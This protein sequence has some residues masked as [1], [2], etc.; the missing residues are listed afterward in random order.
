MRLTF[1]EIE[2]EI[3]PTGSAAWNGGKIE[4]FSIAIDFLNP[5]RNARVIVEENLNTLPTLGD[6]V[7]ISVNDVEQPGSSGMIA[8]QIANSQEDSSVILTGAPGFWIE[9]INP[10]GGADIPVLN[11]NDADLDKITEPKIIL[12]NF[13]RY[14]DLPVQDFSEI[15]T[16]KLKIGELRGEFTT[17]DNA[18]FKYNFF[19]GRELELIFAK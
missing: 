2:F 14:N 12:S 1:S 9:N 5:E 8:M 4:D 11:P 19:V 6:S 7:V 10:L 15:E 3:T 16:L 18:A 17:G 13:F